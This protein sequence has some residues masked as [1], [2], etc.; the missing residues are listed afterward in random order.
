MP[1]AANSLGSNGTLLN[2]E[3]GL[4]QNDRSL[5]VGYGLPA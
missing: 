3:A 5:R 1:D 2:F 4:G